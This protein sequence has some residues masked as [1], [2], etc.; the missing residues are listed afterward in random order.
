MVSL[1]TLK[2]LPDS[3][4]DVLRKSL[5]LFV[6]PYRSLVREYTPELL[7]LLPLT[8]AD[9]VLAVTIEDGKPDRLVMFFFVKSGDHPETLLFDR[10]ISGFQD[11]AA[12]YEAF[13]MSTALEI[14][15]ERYERP[16]CGEPWTKVHQMGLYSLSVWYVIDFTIQR[17]DHTFISDVVMYIQRS[18]PGFLQEQFGI[19]NI[20]SIT[21]TITDRPLLHLPKLLRSYKQI[22]PP[23]IS[24]TDEFAALR[25]L[26][27]TSDIEEEFQK[28]LRDH[29]HLL[30]LVAKDIQP[31]IKL[32]AE[33]VTDFLIVEA[34][35]VFNFVEI[36]RPR[37]SLLT[38][39]GTQ[40]AELTQALEQIG[41]WRTWLAENP[42]YFQRNFPHYRP[43]RERFT[44]IAGRMPTD[45]K[46]WQRL[47]DRERQN[48]IDLVTYDEVIDRMSTAK[49][50]LVTTI[51][52]VDNKV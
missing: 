40:A 43:G 23:I 28:F 10:D 20:D 35:D 14:L 31:K 45:V 42:N 18:S 38:V 15:A 6:E 16:Q 39:R 47:Q 9:V 27:A 46:S 52:G 36:E 12:G 1:A 11:E 7:P 5:E 48:R 4:H 33:F 8:A 21:R 13:G 26:L 25:D 29:S 2:A 30:S 17:P 49:E 32:G 51:R 22:I 50:R 41:Q 24:A 34:G 44:L 37:I 19:E 3:G